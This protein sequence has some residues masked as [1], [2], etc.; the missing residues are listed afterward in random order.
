MPASIS[1]KSVTARHHFRL[2]STP[3]ATPDEPWPSWP[4]HGTGGT[5]VARRRGM[6]APGS[7]TTTGVENTTER[8]GLVTRYF[9]P[10]LC[11]RHSPASFIGSLGL[12]DE[13]KYDE[14]TP[15]HLPD[16]WAR[17]S[18]RPCWGPAGGPPRVW[19]GNPAATEPAAEESARQVSSR[20]AVHTPPH[21]LSAETTDFMRTFHSLVIETA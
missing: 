4:C 20:R 21:R 14:I 18:P 3:H 7:I 16:L 6:V 12:K 8:G 17:R 9:A 5:P 2:G 1:L 13:M 19:R 11:P 15:L 10:S